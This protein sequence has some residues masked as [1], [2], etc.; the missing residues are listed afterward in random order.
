MSLQAL[1]PQF[2]IKCDTQNCD[3]KIIT[4]V[5]DAPQPGWLFSEF[6]QASPSGCTT[7]WKRHFCPICV[8]KMHKAFVA[9]GLTS[10]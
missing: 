2:E 7:R 6:F 8:E 5:S 10:R 4:H 3:T 9:N 1:R